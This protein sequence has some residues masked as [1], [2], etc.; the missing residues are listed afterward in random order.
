MFWP[1]WIGD[2]WGAEVRRNSNFPGLALPR[3]EYSVYLVSAG[4]FHTIM[5]DVTF[6]T[7]QA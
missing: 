6:L 4:A 1:I 5:V 7:L 3:S 2:W